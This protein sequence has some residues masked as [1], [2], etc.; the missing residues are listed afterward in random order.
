MHRQILSLFTL[1]SVVNG[2]NNTST[3]NNTTMIPFLNNGIPVPEPEPLCKVCRDIVD[4]IR[5]ELNVSNKTIN[6]TEQIIKAL[7]KELGNNITRRECYNIVND[8]DRIKNWIISGLT[9]DKICI[10]LGLCSLFLYYI[11]LLI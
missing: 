3:Y 6:Q 11:R 1:F 8:I 7:C 5:W 2:Y 4:V 9:P 10:K